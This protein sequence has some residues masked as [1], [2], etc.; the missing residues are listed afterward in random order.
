L[1]CFALLFHVLS[2]ALL[3]VGWI[4]DWAIFFFVSI[5]IE[6]LEMR[7]GKQ[8][9]HHIIISTLINYNINNYWD[10]LGV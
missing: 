10:D 4:G 6:E 8:K 3:C 5:M 7:R 9:S 2:L 1:L